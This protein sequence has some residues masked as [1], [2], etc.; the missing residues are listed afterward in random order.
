MLDSRDTVFWALNKST[1]KVN[2]QTFN[3]NKNVYNLYILDY[4]KSRLLKME[5]D[6]QDDW[7]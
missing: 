3:N 7:W 5:L 6:S 4:N 2:W 1:P